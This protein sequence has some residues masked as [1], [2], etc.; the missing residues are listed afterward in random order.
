VS[1]PVDGTSAPRLAHIDALRALA[2]LAVAVF[3]FHRELRVLPVV[4]PESVDVVLAHGYLG[5]NIFFVLSG[6]VIAW[7]LRDARYSLDVVARFALRRSLRLDPPYW[8]TVALAAV[9]VARRVNDPI[10]VSV[11]S[12]V[13]HAFY[14][15]N[16][17][18]F[19]NFLDVFWT[20]CIEVQ[21]YL[22]FCLL[23]GLAQSLG[24][25]TRLPWKTG[26]LGATTVASLALPLVTP[27]E[28][29]S[30][31]FMTYWYQ[32][33]LGVWACWCTS[34]R[35]ARVWFAMAVGGALGLGARLGDSGPAVCAVTAAALA[36]AQRWSG[37]ATSPGIIRLALM[38][39]RSYSF[40]LLHAL[41]GVGFLRRWNSIVPP[42]LVHDVVGL[43][44]AFLLA[45][46]SAELLH[47]WV[48]R[49]SLALSRRIR[50]RDVAKTPSSARVEAA[51]T[52][53]G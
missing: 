2:A 4:I 10:P 52:G 13:A 8:L 29:S 26:L 17:L 34:S 44:V 21:L 24:D 50:L 46:A 28:H 1:T 30:G 27:A 43:I 39:R 53:H 37:V 42:S 38:G 23:A 15:Q 45:F 22:F 20:L 25:M 41:V 31:W 48:E 32:F 6:F 16:I 33:A 9:V 5:V 14:L 11:A 49:P 18:G 35:G 36:G 12:V 3:H 47:R 7:S 40:Y 51:A 19:R